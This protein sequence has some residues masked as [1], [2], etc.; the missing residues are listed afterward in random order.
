M[1][2]GRHPTKLVQNTLGTEIP[3]DEHLVPIIELLWSRQIK[4]NFCCQGD[5]QHSGYIIFPEVSGAQAFLAALPWVADD[6]DSPDSLNKR[7][8]RRANLSTP[9]T[10][11]TNL[12]SFKLQP[13]WSYLTQSLNF[14]ITVFFPHRDIPEILQRLKEKFPYE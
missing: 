11:K 13:E 1:Y 14:R 10:V 2:N 5:E 7:L 6:T 8:R 3:I 4:T 12:W 9:Q